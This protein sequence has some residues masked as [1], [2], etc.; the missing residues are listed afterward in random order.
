MSFEVTACHLVHFG[1][2]KVIAGRVRGVVR[3]G[4]RETFMGNTT[5]YS[6]DLKVRAECE[7]FSQEATR[8][9]L[10]AHAAHQLNRLKVRHDAHAPMAAE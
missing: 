10:L 5:N 9:A 3:V 1:A 2:D 8:S 4:I 6:L 7:G